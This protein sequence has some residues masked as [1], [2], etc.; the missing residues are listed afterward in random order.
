MGQ[1]QKEKKIRKHQTIAPHWTHVNGQASCD[2]P[3]NVSW[4]DRQYASVIIPAIPW[5]VTVL[6]QLGNTTPGA[7][8][9]LS[10]ARF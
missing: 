8:H 10:V 4:D 1:L 7:L 5:T 2:H 9:L 6:V 3:L